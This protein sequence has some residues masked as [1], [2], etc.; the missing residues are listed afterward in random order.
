MIKIGLIGYG[1]WGP[2]LVRNFAQTPNCKIVKI[3]DAN[4]ERLGVVKKLY[5]EI[6]LTTNSQDLIRCNEIDA[7]IIATPVFTHYNI[8][9][10]ALQNNKHVLIEKPMTSDVESSIELINIAKSKNLTLMIDHTFLYTDSVNKIKQIINEGEL[11]DLKYFDSTRINLGLFQPDVN[12][13]WD[14]APH[15]ISILLFLKNEFPISVNATGISHTG[16][17]IENIAYLTINYQSNFIAHI[18]CSWTS[19]T[20]VRSTLIGGSKKMIMYND[21]EPS[22]KI[23]I[24]DTSYQF[25]NSE[26]KNRILVDYRIG[27]ISLPK[28]SNTEALLG[29]ANDFIESISNNKDPISNSEIGLSVVKIL[30]AAQ[31]SIKSKGK[32]IKL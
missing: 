26:D 20:K 22:E 12:V 15:D 29:V 18:N 9:K 27:D 31:K 3:A 28:I 14:L 32:E 7:I 30:E 11:G 24:Y 10:S 25:K 19:P 4:I 2:N 1:Y 13:L 21:L 8:A 5:P 17:D 6:E 16:N 23:R